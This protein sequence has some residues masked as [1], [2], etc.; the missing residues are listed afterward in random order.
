MLRIY[1]SANSRA[2]RVL[3][4]A[5]ELGIPYDHKDWLPRAPETRTPEYRA[6]NPLG[7][8]PTIDDDGFVLAESM[9]VNFYL[10]KK[11]RSALCPVDI[12]NEA[13]AL[14]WCLW[15]T[16]R[17]DRQIVD[18]GRH[19]GG[20]PEAER[21]P[22]IAEAMW[23][24]LSAGFDLLESALSKSKWLAGPEFSV[25]DLNV[26]A[27]LLRALTLDLA[28]WPHFKTWLNTCWDRPAAK[29]VRAMRK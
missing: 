24:A 20:L 27:A 22:E 3:W 1:G 18:Y 21:K 10:A 29:K 8:V 16:D 4:M 6:L 23:K 2:I 19:T 9:A 7:Q 5:H 13:L 14:Q 26:S 11:N 28:I 17:M 15:E 12:K 25:A